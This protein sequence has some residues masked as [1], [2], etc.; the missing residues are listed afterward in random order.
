MLPEI[1]T[2]VPVE[3]LR[4]IEPGI[5]AWQWHG[6]IAELVFPDEREVTQPMQDHFN[7]ATTWL[8][9]RKLD[10]LHL[11]E[12]PRIWFWTDGKTMFI[13]WD[14]TELT[15]DGQSVWASTKR[16]LLNATEYIH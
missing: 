4:K 1:L 12:G 8:R 7:L 13:S 6:Q 10:V 5:D 14:N 16:N 9:G 2:A 15:V 11:K 3:S